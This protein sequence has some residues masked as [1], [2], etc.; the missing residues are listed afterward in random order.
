MNSVDERLYR[1]YV[2][3][4]AGMAD[5]AGQALV[6][7]RDIR[8]HLPAGAAGRAVLDIGSGQGELVRMLLADGFA[9]QGVDISAEQVDRAHRAG[10][11]QIRLGDFH[12]VLGSA[13]GVWDAIVATDVLEHLGKEE[14]L[15][16]FDDVHRALRPGGVFLARVPN[17]VSPT[18]GHVMFSDFTHRTWFTQHSIRQLA[19]VAGFA[20]V[21]AF[22]C[23]P[24]VHGFRSA[25]RGL[26]W[27][28]VSGLLKLALAAE[29]GWLRGHIVTQNLSFAAYREPGAR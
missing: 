14:V 17:A 13:S 7:R 28:P 12:E 24:M 22:A 2:S 8:P 26:A 3:T 11:P 20:A 15:R 4:H 29:T 25:L 1:D 9:A 5:T 6:Y 19:A 10:V 27:K 18:G 21:R 16:T 23:P